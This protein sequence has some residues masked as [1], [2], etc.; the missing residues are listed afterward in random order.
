MKAV[1]AT[2][3]EPILSEEEKMLLS[4][5]ITN[6]SSSPATNTHFASDPK[7]F[8]LLARVIE[9]Q[10]SCQMAALFLLR[11]MV[12]HRELPQGHEATILALVERMNSHG[13]ASF[14]GLPAS[15]MA[16]CTIANWMSHDRQEILGP[17]HRDVI[18]DVAMRLMT[19]HDK[20][21]IKQM[22]AALAYNVTLSCTQGNVITGY[23]SNGDGNNEELHPHALQLLCASLEDIASESS[24]EVRRRRLAI[25][26]RIAR[27]QRHL[28]AALASD[29]GFV[30]ALMQFQSSM[31]GQSVK[32]D[33]VDGNERGILHELLTLLRN[34]NP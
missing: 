28:V 12:L 29:L 27:A 18:I 31:E 10:P 25:A 26:L 5:V 2:T 16:V 23:W 32:R 15:V 1:D 20:N 3:G 9:Q 17:A 6:L 19:T 22:S 30:D 24:K 11:L 8:T 4:A 21:E 34:N 14:S 33:D 7:T 13:T